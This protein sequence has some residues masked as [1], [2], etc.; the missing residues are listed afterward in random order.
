MSRYLVLLLS[1]IAS[2]VQAE[3]WRVAGDTQFA[4]YSFVTEDDDIPRGLDV[5]LVQAVLN[6]ARVG[7]HIRLYPWQRVKR[8]L[9]TGQVRMAFPFAGTPDRQAEY[10]LVGPLRSGMTVFMVRNDFP[11]RD[12]KQL[13]DLQPYIIG[14]VQG[15]AYEERFDLH[16]LNRDTSSVTPRQLVSMLLAGRVDVIIGDRIQLLH[17]AQ[18]KQVQDQVRL[19]RKPLI[20]MPRFVAFRKGDLAH[21]REFSEALVRLRKRG[22][23]ERIIERWDH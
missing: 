16:E 11:L 2:V 13:D 4:P 18:E 15:Y 5:E 1:L 12:W 6:E 3:V 22:E 17:F 23:L 19:L 14:Q 10:D 20:E 7:Y 8:M 9:H 21:A